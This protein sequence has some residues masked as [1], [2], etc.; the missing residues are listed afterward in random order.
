VVVIHNS[1]IYFW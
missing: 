1:S